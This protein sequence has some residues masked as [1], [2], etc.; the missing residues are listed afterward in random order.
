MSLAERLAPS[1]TNQLATVAKIRGGHQHGLSF[2][3][4]P[5]QIAVEVVP[6]EHANDSAAWDGHGDALTVL[7]QDRKR[8]GSSCDTAVLPSGDPFHLEEKS[9]LF[10]AATLMRFA[11]Y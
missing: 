2:P 3:F 4:H 11:A 7:N 9:R 8:G 5:W 1:P 6:S 10:R